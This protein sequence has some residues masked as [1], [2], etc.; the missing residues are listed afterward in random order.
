MEKFLKTLYQKFLNF[1]KR[2][3]LRDAKTWLGVGDLKLNKQTFEGFFENYQKTPFFSFLGRIKDIIY[4]KNVFDYILK[5]STDVWDLWYHLKFLENQ[6]ILNV[7]R[8]GN[9]SILNKSILNLIP[10]PQKESEIKD[11]IEKKLKIKIKEKEPVINLFKKFTPHRNKISGAGFQDFKVKAK[12]DQ[13]PIS[14]SSAIFLTKKIL[15]KLPL[16]KTFLFIGD[17]D[18]ISVI[19]SLAEPKIESLVID[20]DEDLLARIKGLASKFNLKIQT[21]KVDIRKEESLGE[22]FL[23]FLCNPVYTEEG[24]KEFM[25]YGKN[26]LG[27]DGGIVF[28]EVGDEAIGN[29]FSFLQDFFIKKSLIIKEIIPNK[30]YYPWISLHKEDKIISK[31]L[32][33]ILNEKTVKASPKLGASLYVFDYLPFEIKRIKIKKPIYSYL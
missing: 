16:N 25:N 27:E 19:L 26:Q 29:R 2:Y 24:V 14:E 5:N 9:V 30:I 11:K 32:F 22:K 7:K 8:N 20:I 6:K 10:Q 17:D 31:R 15:E 21:K 18:F 13:M 12:W 3:Y 23:G 28:L 1:E 33:S 4:S